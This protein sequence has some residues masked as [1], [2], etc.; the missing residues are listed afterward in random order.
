LTADSSLSSTISGS[1]LTLVLRRVGLVLRRA[2]ILFPC[3]EFSGGALGLKTVR[4]RA[5]LQM[6]RRLGLFS[7]VW[8]HATVSREVEDIERDFPWLRSVLLAP[9]VRFLPDPPVEDA[10]PRA[11]D[12]RVRL[13]FLGR[14]GRMKKL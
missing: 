1:L 6:A 10:W 14:I 7:G 5:Y 13:A 9:N 8:L 4:K 11:G 3:G 12:R 2:T